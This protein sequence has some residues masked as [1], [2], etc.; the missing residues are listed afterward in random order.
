[1]TEKL[2]CDK[3]GFELNDKEAIY[4]AL[5]GTQAWQNAQ[6]ERGCE[7]RGL[8]PCKYY[9]QCQGEMQLVRDVKDVKKKRALFGREKGD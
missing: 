1:M 9:I 6:R 7:P 3:C 8:F 2:I 4:M 5:D